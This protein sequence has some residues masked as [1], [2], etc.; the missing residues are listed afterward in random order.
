MGRPL[1]PPENRR[2][3]FKVRAQ[4]KIVDELTREA[5]EEDTTRQDVIERALIGYVQGK[6]AKAND[7]ARK[8]ATKPVKTPASLK[9]P[10]RRRPAAKSKPASQKA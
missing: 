7:Q 3:A 4:Q 8:I 6:L 1:I 9:T 5:I 2:I 10:K